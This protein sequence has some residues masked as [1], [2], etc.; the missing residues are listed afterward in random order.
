[1]MM[2][3]SCMKPRKFDVSPSHLHAD[4][5]NGMAWLH[6][7]RWATTRLLAG[8]EVIQSLLEYA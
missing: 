2:L 6:S 5:E 3:A 4:T 1:M 7:T 8:I